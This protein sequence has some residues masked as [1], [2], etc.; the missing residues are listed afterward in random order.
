MK[1]RK[2]KKTPNS[3]IWGLTGGIASGK[4]TAAAF[5]KDAGIPVIDADDIVRELSAPGGLAYPLIVKKFG[6]ADREKLCAIILKDAEARQ[7]LEAIL[8]PLVQA[9]SF[10][11]A[12][13]LAQPHVIYEAALLVETGR[14]RELAGLIVVNTPAE[15]RIKRLMKRNRLSEDT[16]KKLIAAQTSDEIRNAAAT[17]VMNNVGSLSDLK[18]EVRKFLLEKKWTEKLP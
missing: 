15:T 14:Y 17:H 7:D 3:K 2:L 18:T 8:H 13:K 10:A 11:R 9:E 16:A 1:P 6:T 12:E 5:F 4:S